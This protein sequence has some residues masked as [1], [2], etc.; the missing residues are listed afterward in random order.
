[1]DLVTQTILIE[2]TKMKKRAFELL[3]GDVV[4]SGE[5]LVKDAVTV[6]HFQNV[7]AS[8]TLRHPKTGKIRVASWGKYTLIGVS[9]GSVKQGED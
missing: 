7:K 8:V 3:A 2:E 5:I 6:G 1:M 4:S 9:S